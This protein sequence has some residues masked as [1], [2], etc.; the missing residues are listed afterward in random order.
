LHVFV[1]EHIFFNKKFRGS[2]C[3]YNQNRKEKEGT[4]CV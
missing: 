1:Y 3:I 4:L 2:I